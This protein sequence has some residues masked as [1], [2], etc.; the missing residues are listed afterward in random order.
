MRMSFRIN[1]VYAQMIQSIQANLSTCMNDVIIF[2]DDANMD[3]V[4]L[5]IVKKSQV[6]RFTFFNKTERFALSALL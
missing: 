3:D 5:L 1:I 4:A 6:T 2:Q